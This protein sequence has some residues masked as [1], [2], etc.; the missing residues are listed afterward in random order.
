MSLVLNTV[1]AIQL[2]AGCAVEFEPRVTLGATEDPTG[3]G[4]FAEVLDMGDQGYL[5]S[6]E[7]LGG[8]VIVY[9]SEGRYQ[10]ELTREG[11]GPG[12]LRAP[13][14]FASGP[15]GIILMESASARL[16][17]Y[18]S[19][20]EFIRTL[21]VPGATFLGSI[22]RN[23]ATGGWLVSYRGENYGEMGILL[24]DQEGTVVRSMQA[25]EESGDGLAHVI[26]GTDG[27]MWSSSLF[28]RVQLLD[29]DLGILGSLQLELP[30]MEGWE[31]SARETGGWPAQINDIRL[32]PDGSGLWVFAVAAEERFVELSLDEF[33][34]EVMANRYTPEQ[35]VDAYLFGVRLEPDGLTLVGMDHFDTLVRPLGDG[36]LAYDLLE[37]PDGN[38][39]VRVGRLRFTRTGPD[40][41][42][43]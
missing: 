30:G 19:N 12:E 8:V 26:P 31:E 6:S 21:Q 27:M 1:S 35:V 2:C 23:P 28:G 10:R 17:L 22:R 38:R 3:P 36:D 25:G 18:T 42:G 41:P 5:V 39:R 24:L 33:R 14:R 34:D 7:V 20:L 15:G 40:T 16:H 4:T 29:E 13:P 43:S 32:A 37:T 9:D 11:E